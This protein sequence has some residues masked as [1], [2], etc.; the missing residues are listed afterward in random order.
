MKLPSAFARNNAF[1]RGRRN[2]VGIEHLVAQLA[3]PGLVQGDNRGE[4]EG[5]PDQPSRD[6][7][8]LL[9]VR[10]ERETED[11]HHQ[12]RKK[13]HGVERIFRAPLQADIFRQ[14]GKVMER[15]ELIA[16]P[17]ARA[18]MSDAMS[19][20]MSGR[21]SARLAS[22]QIRRPRLPE[23]RPGASPQK[24]FCRRRACPLSKP[25]ISRA[26][27]TS[28]L[29]NGSSSNRILGSCRMARASDMRCR[30]P[31]EYLPTGRDNSGSSPTERITCSQRSS[32]AIS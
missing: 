31:C 24:W 32:P 14:R 12:Q 4:Q 5:D 26:E 21:R 27:C 3:R 8:R 29:E 19:G 10:I 9:G 11:H 25:T 30:M 2:A 7:P 15:S 1:G 6:F 28:T 17:L 18:S 23:A 20:P 13:Q 16:P 22:T